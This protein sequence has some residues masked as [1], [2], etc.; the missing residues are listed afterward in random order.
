M[1]T[2]RF[3]AGLEGAALKQLSVVSGEDS[4]CSCSKCGEM[5]NRPCWPTPDEAQKLIE[6]GYGDRLMLD[7]W[8]GDGY[9]GGDIRLISPANQGY[10]GKMAPSWP[11]GACTFYKDGLCG[12]HD[13]GLKPIE[14][15]RA[16]CPTKGEQ[17]G[18]LHREVAE[19]WNNPDSQTFTREWYNSRGA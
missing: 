6:A 19:T 10:E 8:V 1:C 3:R 11:Q 14:G 16:T 13:L 7:Y 5:C 4:V 15:R 18:H 9:A 17:P 12:L 2:R